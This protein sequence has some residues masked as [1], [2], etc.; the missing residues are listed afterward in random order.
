MQGV[1]QKT[2]RFG[3]DPIPDVIN[4]MTLDEKLDVL[5][6]STCKEKS[7]AAATIG[8]SAELVPGAA[9]QLNGVERLGIP[10][11]VVADG[12]A[13]LRIAPTRKGTSQT[14]Y[15]THFPIETVMS[16]TWNTDLVYSIGAAMGDEV[17]HYGVDVL[18]APATNIH[19]NPLNVLNFEY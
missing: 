13:G 12:P 15:C 11:T 16:S 3:V 7:N 19:R 2:P 18:L 9:G 4:A 17:K 14:F 6:G 5:V 1:A 10:T 8:N